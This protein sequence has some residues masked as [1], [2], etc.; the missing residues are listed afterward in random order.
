MAQASAGKQKKEQQDFLKATF[1]SGLISGTMNK[2]IT[3]PFDTIKAKIQIHQ[4]YFNSLQNVHR[5]GFI[6][7]ARRTLKDHGVKEFYRGVTLVCVMGAPASSLFFGS[8]QYFKNVLSETSLGPHEMTRNFVAANLAEAVSCVLWV[9][10]DVLKE[11]LQVQRELGFTQYRT[12]IQSLMHV[13]RNESYTSLYR[14]YGATLLSFGPFIGTNLMLYEKLKK[15]MQSEGKD[16]GFFRSFSASL[17]TGMAASLLTNPFDV[18]RFRMQVQRAEMAGGSIHS[19]EEGSYGY[20]NVF[21]GIAK[22]VQREGLLALWRGCGARIIHMSAQAAVN[23]SLL[24]SVRLR[25]LKVLR[26]EK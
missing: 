26:K 19:L 11:R 24:E 23:L 25:V 20:K 16:H 6:N 3:H 17:V 8:Y 7:T 13:L 4:L 5:T 12:G 2:F 9:P 22:I 14:A 18:A 1:V 15:W 21:D 10:I